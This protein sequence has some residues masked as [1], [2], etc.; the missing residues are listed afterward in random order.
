M[1][2]PV[3]A[4]LGSRF[5]RDARP[6]QNIGGAAGDEQADAQAE[7]EGRLAG[8]KKHAVAKGHAC[9]G[10]GFGLLANRSVFPPG[11]DRGTENRMVQNTRF[12]GWRGAGKAASCKDE[13]DR[14]WQKRKECSHQTKPD[15][16]CSQNFER[17][18]TQY[19]L[20]NRQIRG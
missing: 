18:S 6:A 19:C 8:K 15:T 14:A 16:A 1:S 4:G 11:N 2:E 10:Q 13:K 3:R 17:G 9:N 20:R 12:K 7:P 5:F